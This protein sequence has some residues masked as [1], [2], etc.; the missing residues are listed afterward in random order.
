[1]VVDRQLVT[2]SRHRLSRR[3]AVQQVY[4]V[5]GVRHL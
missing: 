3:I 4:F 5:A 2:R 1:M